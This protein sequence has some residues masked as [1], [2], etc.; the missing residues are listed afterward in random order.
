M[1]RLILLIATISGCAA[2]PRW[3][4]AVE[5]RVEEQ[6]PVVAMKLELHGR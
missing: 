5:A 1:I 4:A 3:T 2:P 6:R